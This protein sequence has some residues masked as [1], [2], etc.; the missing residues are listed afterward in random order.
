MVTLREEFDVLVGYS[1]HTETDFAAL[2]SV[3]LG[4]GVVEK[5]FTLDKTLPG[6]DHTSSCDPS[7]LARLIEG[8]RA[9]ESA[10]GSAKKVP[11]ERE[12]R[13]IEGMRRSVVSLRPITAGE[14]IMRDALGFKRPATGISPSRL[15]EVVGRKARVDIPA[16]IPLQ[17]DMII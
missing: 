15:M 4:A 8:I 17:E 2:A 16:D 11:T 9:V 1:D 7:D 13:N 10:L 3:A 14:E 12:I 6:P 5:H